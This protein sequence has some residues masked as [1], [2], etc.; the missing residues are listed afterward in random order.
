M[1]WIT[2]KK[3]E[4]LLADR[5]IPVFKIGLLVDGRVKP[6]FYAYKGSEYVLNK[7]YVEYNIKPVKSCLPPFDPTYE[8]RRALHSYSTENIRLEACDGVYQ[9]ESFVRIMTHRA[10]PMSPVKI[11]SGERYRTGEIK[12]AL[13]LCVIPKGTPYYVNEKGEIASERLLVKKIIKNP[14]RLGCDLSISKISV[15]NVNEEIDKFEKQY[16]DC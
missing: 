13:I 6:Y 3:P 12:L 15:E 8:I 16:E 14:F 9:G 5:P 4:R 11:G 10:T 7:L 1:C 2:C